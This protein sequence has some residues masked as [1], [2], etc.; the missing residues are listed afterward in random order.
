MI[1]T[2]AQKSVVL[3]ECF[4]SVVSRPITREPVPARPRRTASVAIP[5]PSFPR[6]LAEVWG[7]FVVLSV[8]GLPAD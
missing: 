6:Y 4:V 8:R 1:A 5:V 7:R 3:S 2:I